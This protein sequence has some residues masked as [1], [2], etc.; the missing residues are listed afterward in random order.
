MKNKILG[1]LYGMAIGDAMGMPSE[2]WTRRKIKE[3]F[4]KIEGFLEGPKESE[5][6]MYY[7]KGQFTDDTGEAIAILKSLI[8]TNFVPDK[9]DIA[10]EL[11][12]WAIAHNAFEY[13]ILGPSSKAALMAIREGKDPEE[14]TCKAETNGAAMRIAPIGCLFSCE[15]KDNLIEYVVNVSSV[16]H[17]TDVALGGASMVAMA[18][19]SALEDKSWD[20][21]IKN[22]I[23]AYTKA[24]SF[25]AETF[26]PS[27]LER[28]NLGLY[29][30]DKYKD[31]S[32]SF[33]QKIFDVIGTGVLTSESVP[34]A[35]SIAYYAKEPE[36]C[37]IMCANLGGDTDTIGAMA[38]AICGAKSGIENIDEKWIELINEKNR[39]DFNI[40]SDKINNFRNKK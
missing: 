30:A 40:Y 19:S 15:D 23:E 13:N 12:K 28:L 27:L 38:T 24:K 6:A 5:L 17:N 3:Y 31:D 25:G 33:L 18:V 1:A 32:E 36:L 35:M 10:D 37:S 26:S 39:V 9:N 21:I 8:K 20:E 7:A 29:Y 2:F 14:F 34:A 4:G 16:T 11:I 22:S